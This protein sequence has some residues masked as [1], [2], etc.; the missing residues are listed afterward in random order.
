MRLLVI[1]IAGTFSFFTV[2]L[3]LFRK[4]CTD[5][6]QEDSISMEL[7]ERKEKL[8]RK[9][10]KYKNNKYKKRRKYQQK[11]YKLKGTHTKDKRY[12]NQKDIRRMHTSYA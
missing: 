11:H 5:V 1:L 7:L 12:S 3:R 2:D 6:Y 8:K 4:S 9:Q 10:K